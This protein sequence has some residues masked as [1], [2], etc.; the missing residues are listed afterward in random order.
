MIEK[1]NQMGRLLQGCLS[2]NSQERK[3]SEERL[4]QLRGQDPKE[5]LLQTV[6][7]LT[8]DSLSDE[9]RSLAGILLQRSVRVCNT[10]KEVSPW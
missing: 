7:E 6:H 4:N 2:K 3:T 9:I 8:D 10:R 1:E 5:F